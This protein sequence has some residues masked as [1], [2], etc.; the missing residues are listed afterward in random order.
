MPDDGLA[1]GVR[2]DALL[3]LAVTSSEALMLAQVLGP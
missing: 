1:T 2:I 3:E